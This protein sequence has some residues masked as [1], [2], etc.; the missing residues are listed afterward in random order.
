MEGEVVTMQDLVALEIEGED[1]NGKLITT[2]KPTGLRP[3]FY[4]QAKQYGIEE[5]VLEAMEGAFG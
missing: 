1:E 5:L 3:K 4:D 2:Q